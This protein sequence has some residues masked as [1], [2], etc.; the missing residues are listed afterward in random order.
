MR[1]ILLLVACLLALLE[2]A[3]AGSQSCSVEQATNQVQIDDMLRRGKVA[4]VTI[5]LLTELQT[6]AGKAPDP[7]RPLAEQLDSHAVARFAEIG[8]QLKQMKLSA[9]V[10]SAH[11]RDANVVQQ[12]IAAAWKSYADPAYVPE[13]GDV[14]AAA[15]MLMRLTLKN[16]TPWS[17]PMGTGCSVD[18]AIAH[19]QQANFARI[20]AI[21][22]M[23]NRDVSVIQRL[24]AHYGVGQDDTL[25]PEKMG[26]VLI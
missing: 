19:Q 24:R 5:P 16:Q 14:P 22:P 2:T 9:Y 10:E 18:A 23:L 26:S 12:M 6:I 21:T 25:D 8:Q 13:A 17:P 11:A 15:V 7:H 20:N 3:Q 4:Q 1:G